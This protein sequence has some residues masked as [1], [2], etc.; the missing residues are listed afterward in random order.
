MV[1]YFCDLSSD[2]V[3]LFHDLLSRGWGLVRLQWLVLVLSGGF[4]ECLD[5]GDIVHVDVSH[6]N[7][8]VN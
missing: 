2:E 4:E 1:T 7:N 6:L 3:N 5:S 8:L